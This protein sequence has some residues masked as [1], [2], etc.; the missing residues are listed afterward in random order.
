MPTRPDGQPG[1]PWCDHT[2]PYV[3]HVYLADPDETVC[4]SCAR[5]YAE[6][7]REQY[8]DDW[9]GYDGPDYRDTMSGGTIC[10]GGW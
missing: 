4:G 6:W 10:L 1:C 3:A 8:R 2:P 5:S 7:E 9:D